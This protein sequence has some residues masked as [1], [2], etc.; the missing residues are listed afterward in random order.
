LANFQYTAL[1]TAGHRV[2]GALAGA[3]EQAVLAE[4]EARRLTPV[5]IR[6]ES[7][8][9]S[10]RRRVGLRALG[11]SYSQ[12][13]DLLRAGVP[14]LRG[15]KLLAGRKAAP[16]LSA[17]YRELSDAVEKG[18]DL[19]AA[20]GNDPGV[21]PHV[22]IAMVRAGEKGG[23]L[24]DVLDK[25]GHMVVKQVELRAK[26]VG[27]LVYP[28]V[29]VAMG[30][31]VG[32][33]I[34]GVFVPKFR[35]IF[36][37]M[38]GGLPW[39][40]RAV[41]AASDALT[42]Y[43][44]VTA[45][46]VGLLAFALWRLMRRPAVRVRIERAQARTPIIGAIVRGVATARLCRL[47]GAMLANGVPLLAALQIA[48]DGTGNSLMRAAVEE[49]IESVRAGQPLAPPLAASGLIDDDIAEMIAV[50]ESANNLDDVLA[51]VSETIETRLDRVL[52]VAVR[53]IEPL[54]LVI[55]AGIVGVVAAALLLPMSKL[56]GSM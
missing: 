6:E 17:V 25:L 46:V 38:Q 35:P 11:E 27:N 26:V 5:S 14:L 55:L 9:A 41:F 18:S 28:M 1:N 21:F 10:P 53:L 24:E 36:E 29:L 56:S 49:S 19:G 48:K 4:L 32:G 12:L 20:M 42:K 22:H 7:G 30:L 15:L 13:A 45:V 43:G 54:L 33:V 37:K 16:K 50:G 44:L 8:P 52:G 3:N 47:L 23:F 51:K 31:V 39:I 2:T 40:T 34:F